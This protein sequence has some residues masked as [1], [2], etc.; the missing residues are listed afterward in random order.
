MINFNFT[1]AFLREEIDKLKEEIHSDSLTE[2][3]EVTN[4]QIIMEMQ[5]AILALDSSVDLI[6]LGSISPINQLQK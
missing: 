4:F 2:D 5:L 3:G 6:K 1:K